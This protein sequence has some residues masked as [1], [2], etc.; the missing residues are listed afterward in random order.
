M[1]GGKGLKRPAEAIA[2]RDAKQILNEDGVKKTLGDGRVTVKHPF[3]SQ[4]LSTAMIKSFAVDADNDASNTKLLAR[5]TAIVKC[6][7][8]HPNYFANLTGCV[9]MDE[10]GKPRI[11]MVNKSGAIVSGNILG[12]VQTFNQFSGSNMQGNGKFKKQHVSEGSLV[13]NGNLIT[14]PKKDG[15]ILS[16]LDELLSAEH[17][18]FINFMESTQESLVAMDPTDAARRSLSAPVVEDQLRSQ[19]YAVRKHAKYGTSTVIAK[20][21][22]ANKY[23]VGP[24]KPLAEA[25]A[26][27]DEY[28]AD[29]YNHGLQVPEDASDL[30][31]TC[32]ERCTRIRDGIQ[33]INQ[34]VVTVASIKRSAT[35]AP[36]DHVMSVPIHTNFITSSGQSLPQPVIDTLIYGYPNRALLSYFFELLPVSATNIVPFVSAFNY[37]GLRP[38]QAPWVPVAYDS[39]ISAFPVDDT[40][41]ANM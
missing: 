15:S 30:E 9:S 11:E 2:L 23:N 31:Y 6:N 5:V 17:Q 13:M 12:P 24:K 14:D 35:K 29:A 21:K 25:L 19:Q 22:H 39:G 32:Y 33:T 41:I 34:G 10:K 1:L 16:A 18:K 40:E 7:N 3:M 36:V 38:A 20:A 28:F 26:I 4:E 37:I 27:C 8:A